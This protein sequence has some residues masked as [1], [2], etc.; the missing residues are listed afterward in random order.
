MKNK[1]DNSI[2]LFSSYN[3]I[4]TQHGRYSYKIFRNINTKDCNLRKTLLNNCNLQ[5]SKF[6]RCDMSNSDIQGTEFYQ[7]VFFNVVFDGADI[8]SCVFK[9]CTFYS[10]CFGAT[11]IMDNCFSNCKISFCKIETSTINTNIWNFCTFEFFEPKDSALYTNDFLKCNFI[12]CKLLSSIYYSI[13]EKCT[14]VDCEIDSYILGFQ[15][16]LRKKDLK[17]M[18]I[19]HFGN[20]DISITTS[21]KLLRMIYQERQMI[22][23]ELILNLISTSSLGNSIELMINI[24]FKSI[25]DG[26]V[27]KAEHIRFVRRIIDHVYREKKISIYYYY[28][29]I[30]GMKNQNISALRQKLPINVFNELTILYQSLYA[31]KLEQ[32]NYY[33]ELACLMKANY[34]ILNEIKVEFIYKTCPEMRLF[35]ILS[36]VGI[37]SYYPISE[38]VGSFHEIYIIAR[39]VC[40]NFAA[41]I[42]IIGGA[43]G[44]IRALSKLIKRKR[45][46]NLQD[47]KSTPPVEKNNSANTVF[48]ESQEI[49]ELQYGSGHLTKKEVRLDNYNQEVVFYDTIETTIIHKQTIIRSYKKSNIKQI[50]FK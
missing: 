8:S 25:D 37:P 13:F 29:F 20:S 21:I 11:N 1:K 26:Y 28:F 40:N 14:F 15:Y 48:V 23:E 30:E 45:K 32:E 22:L 46:D 50:V 6:Q 5:K 38:G 3:E 12:K 42:T 27:I 16:G 49:K 33:T 35:E 36:T 19:E 31:I 43:A 18:K 44:A 2:Q 39:E 24:L 17:S 41:I 4:N 10:C 34:D 47:K 9:E 7:C